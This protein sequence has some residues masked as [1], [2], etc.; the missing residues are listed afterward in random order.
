MVWISKVKKY[1]NFINKKIFILGI[2]SMIKLN[3]KD[4]EDYLSAWLKWIQHKYKYNFRTKLIYLKKL[5]KK[6]SQFIKLVRNFSFQSHISRRKLKTIVVADENQFIFHKA[7]KLSFSF[8][9][10]MMMFVCFFAIYDYFFTNLPSPLLLN[11]KQQAVTTRIFDRNGILLY[12]IYKDENRTLIPLN[13][14]SPYLVKATIAMEDQNFYDHNGFSLKGIVRAAIAN[15]KGEKI[16]QGGSTITQQLVKNRLLTSERTIQR[17]IRELLLSVLVEG[18][19]SKTQILE[20]Y[21][22][23]VPYGGTVYGIEEAAW[24]YFNKSAKNLS[25]AESALLAGLPA[26][27]SIYNPYGPNPELVYQRRNEVLRRMVEEKFI[28]PQQAYKAQITKLKFREHIIDIKA[29][30]FVMYVKKMLAQKFGEEKLSQGGLQVITTLDYNL[31]TQVENIVRD[32][33]KKIKHLNI[34]NGASLVTNPKTGEVLAMVG[35]VNFF[36]FT[37][38]G[39]V[40]VTL[41]PRQPGSSIKPLTYAVALEQGM[42]LSTRIK[43]AP[44]VFRSAGSQPYKPTNYD[45]KYHG[46]PSIRESLASSYNIPAVKTLNQIGIDNMINKAEEM[47]ITTWQDRSRFG[48]ALTLGGGE[49][50]MSDMAVLYGTF[51]NQGKKVALDPILEVKDSHGQVLYQNSCYEEKCEG[52]QVL[53]QDVAYLITSALSDDIARSPAFGRNSVL[54]IPNQE[55]AVKTGTTNE[56][57]D[58]WTIGYTSDKLVAVWVGNNDNSRMSYV[59]SGITGASPIWNKIMRSLL[60]DNNPHKFSKPDS[61]I[62][63]DICTVTGTLP[64]AGCPQVRKEYFADGTQPQ[65]FCNTAFFHK[66]E[67]SNKQTES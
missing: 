57:K 46:N 41:R 66:K 6:W 19:Y 60:S 23:Q 25:L 37:N 35:S 11:K 30:H 59:A 1:C 64:C 2:K 13:K 52:K 26:A 18:S 17:K 49:V 45:G 40:N 47:G 36:D 15:F 7:R 32:E 29:P 38:D 48:L 12:R 27:P 54:H 9:I 56:L 34:N 28:T 58:N 62:Q 24:Y 44:V 16:T 51:A 10:S 53:D 31:Q 43:D 65:H 22:N 50:L 39:Q 33:I 4:L 42:T 20:M 5:D 8:G 14:I 61:I 63:V 67:N 21:L 55:V 3:R